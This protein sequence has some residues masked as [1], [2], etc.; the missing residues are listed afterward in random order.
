VN[1]LGHGSGGRCKCQELS[2]IPRTDETDEKKMFYKP[3]FLK[4]S[5]QRDKRVNM[6]L[7]LYA[8]VCKCKNCTCSNYFRNGRKVDEG[9][10]RRGEPKCDVFDT[11]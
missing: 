6:V 7:I 3:F 8:Y 5:T 9:E 11:F 4:N 1:E 10:Q 2:S